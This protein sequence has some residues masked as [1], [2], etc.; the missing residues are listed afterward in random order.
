MISQRL[1]NKL[2]M[3]TPWEKGFVMSKGSIHVVHVMHDEEE[4]LRLQR[5][6]FIVEL[7]GGC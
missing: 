6:S 5:G 3:K 1:Q 7:R 2:T 4:P